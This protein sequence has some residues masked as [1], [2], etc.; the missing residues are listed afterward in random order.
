MSELTL[1]QAM[2]LKG[3]LTAEAA[4]VC[5]GGTAD[6]AQSAFNDLVASGFVKEA[7]PAV[8]ITPEGRERLNALL[9]EERATVDQEPLTQAYHEFDDFNTEM[10]TLMT[11][12]QM[13]DA[14][15]PNDHTNAEYDAKVV[16]RLAPF[17]DRFEPVLDRMI[18]AAPRLAPY[19]GRFTNAVTQVGAGDHSFLARPIADSYHTVWFELHEDLIGLLGRT[20]QEEAEAGRAV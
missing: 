20:R 7:G 6:E 19:R 15:T 8:R 12:W 1:L 14:T 9:E 3:R 4:A 10:K 17:H 16:A 5:A 11:E 2:R 18:A 13:L